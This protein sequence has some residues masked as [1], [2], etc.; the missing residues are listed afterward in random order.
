M[1]T[2]S[3]RETTQL[4][5]VMEETTQHILFFCFCFFHPA[6]E[7]VHAGGRCAHLFLDPDD[8]KRFSFKLQ[9]AN[10]VPAETHRL[11]HLITVKDK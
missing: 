9:L 11:K 2:T 10:V 7:K 6:E 3:V 4:I 8:V 5:I 1:M